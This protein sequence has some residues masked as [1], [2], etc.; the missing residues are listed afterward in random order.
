MGNSPDT[1]CGR[2]STTELVNERITVEAEAPAGGVREPVAFTWRGRRY[3]VTEILAA[4]VDAGFGAGEK[5]RPWYNR[6]HRNYY[7][8]RADGGETYVIYLDRSGSR[9]DWILSRKL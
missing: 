8:V 7:R 9:R 3:E 2:V 4:W 6:R 1:C 5:T